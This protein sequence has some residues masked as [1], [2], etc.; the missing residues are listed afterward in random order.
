MRSNLVQPYSDRLVKMGQR[1][2]YQVT[3]DLQDW[4]RVILESVNFLGPCRS[5]KAGRA[6]PAVVIKGEE[7]NTCIVG[8]TVHVF[9][10]LHSIV[11]CFWLEICPSNMHDNSSFTNIGRR[12]TNRNRSISSSSN[13]LLHVSRHGLY[14]FRGVAGGNIVDDFVSRK[15]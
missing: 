13:I 5:L 1:M 2:R 8:A 3:E 12:I 9:G 14:P 11:V 6:T 15:K 10:C 4:H 7:I